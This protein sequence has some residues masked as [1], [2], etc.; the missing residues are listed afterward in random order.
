[1][2]RL[3]ALIIVAVVVVVDAH[4]SSSSSSS[5]D[6]CHEADD[7]DTRTCYGAACSNEHVCSYERLPIDE[8]CLTS[9][10]C[11]E[12]AAPHQIGICDANHTCQFACSSQCVHD[13]DCEPL[14]SALICRSSGPCFRPHCDAG[15]CRCHDGTGLDLDQD[16]VTCP[17]DCDDTDASITTSL[18][19]LRDADNDYWPACNDD[20]D[21]D[22]ECFVFCVEPNATCPHGYTDVDD[23]N[24]T[25]RTRSQRPDT[26]VPCTEVPVVAEDECDCCDIDKRAHPGSLYA[27]SA[28][29]N[30]GSADYNC[31]YATE[32]RACCIDGL[33]D[34]YVASGT[35]YVWFE[36]LCET[37]T[38]VN[39]TCGGCETLENA[40]AV[41]VAGWACEDECDGAPPS[42]S[43][44]CPNACAGEC[45]CVDAGSPPVL[46]RC[47]KFVDSCIH[48]R[49]TL[50]AD[51]ETCCVAAVY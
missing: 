48:V 46:G 51:A 13:D 14:L 30:C 39:E 24:R 7:C 21:D 1:M 33:N 23:P 25:E 43:S 27:G 5:N 17:D 20:D 2:R 11:C 35:R 19:C 22:D 47:A 31:D 26:G 18:M 28:P 50:F 6:W 38:T 3:L 10:E 34:P 4:S 12:Y 15:L 45:D 40:T 37:P 16:G 8:C 32:E 41:L 42:E 29:N 9:E 44:M 49:P 36:Q